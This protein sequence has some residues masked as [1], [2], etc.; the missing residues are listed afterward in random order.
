[1][2][3]LKEEGARMEEGKKTEADR[4]DITEGQATKVNGMVT[5]KGSLTVVCKNDEVKR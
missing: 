5:E 2:D 4:R 3:K 1:M